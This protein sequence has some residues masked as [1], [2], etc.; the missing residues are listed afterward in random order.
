MFAG[1]PALESPLSM[2]KFEEM[3]RVPCC[4]LLV[5]IVPVKYAEKGKFE[6]GHSSESVSKLSLAQ[7]Q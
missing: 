1:T 5:R 2:A 7:L 3:K 6:L 4:T